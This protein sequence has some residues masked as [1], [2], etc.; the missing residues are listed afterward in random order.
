MSA[1]PNRFVLSALVLACAGLCASMAVAAPAASVAPKASATAK[2]AGKTSSA[3]GI[4]FVRELGGIKEYRLPNGLQVL[5]LPDESQETTLVNITYKVGSRHENYG[6]TGMAH[7]LEHMLFKGTPK[8]KDIPEEMGK[9]G[10]RWNAT[11]SQDRTNYF[12]SFTSSESNLN[13]ALSLEADRMRNSFVAKKDLDS[14]MTVVRNE[15]ERGENEP[16]RVL[17]QRVDGAAYQWHAYSRS[18]IGARS[19][20]ENVPIQNLQAFYQRWY[21]P[22][23]AVLAIGGRFDEAKALAK[24]AELFG[25]IANP[26]DPLPPEYTVEPAQDGERRVTVRRVGGQPISM[27]AYHVPGASHPDTAAVLVLGELLSQRP[28]GLLY[29]ELVDTRKAAVARLSG[30]LNSAPGLMRLI[31]VVN[32]GQSADEVEKR[33]QEIVQGV[34]V[35]AFTEAELTRVREQLTVQ[36][37]ELMKDPQG[38]TSLLSEAIA[39]G[40]WRLIFKLFEDLPKVTL[41]DVER[42][43]GQYLRTENRTVGRYEPTDKPVRVDVPANPDLKDRLAQVAEPPK[44]E[45]AEVFEPSPENLEKRV[46]RKLLPSGIQ[47]SVLP[48][49]TRGNTV[50]LRMDLR[51]AELAQTYNDP[52]SGWVADLLLEGSKSLSKQEIQDALTKLRAKVQLQGGPQGVEVTLQAEKQ[53]LLPALALLASVLREPLLPA[54]ALERQRAASLSSMEASRQEVGTLISEATRP[55]LND[56]MGVKKGDVGYRFSLD[57]RVAN[58]KGLTREA[59]VAFH[60]RYWSANDVQVGVVGPVPEGLE[61][62]LDGLIGSWKKPDAPAYKR[63]ETSH[64][65]VAAARVDV[66]A[67]DK[68]NASMSMSLRF[69]LNDRDADAPAMNLATAIFGSGME[70]RLMKRVRQKEGLTYGIGASVTIT[71]HGDRAG[72]AIGG[73]F[74]PENRDKVI[75]AVQ[76]E[77]RLSLKDGFTQA[78]LDRVRKDTLEGLKQQRADDGHIA[79]TMVDQLQEKQTFREL[80]QEEARIKSVTLEQLNAAWRK[81]V[82]A[83]GFL[84]VTAGDYKARPPVAP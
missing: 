76:D 30:S 57:E 36:Y 75:A 82:N 62:A 63:W 80:A 9:R 52:A 21:R 17:M 45:K 5:L 78:E 70:G 22:D 83:A 20:V 29:K 34:N 25:G 56:A 58:T 38:M 14:E 77:L 54:D 61:Q 74:A 31:T 81:H 40:D 3:A 23:N 18:T 44:V 8:F 6:E 84:T 42:V 50:V 7:L 55:L 1:S 11:T 43:R 4:Q 24:V 10:M 48:K 37:R 69:S 71:E 51:F 35:P 32:Q 46:V 59:I 49:Q 67:T 68:A 53:T 47:Y 19:D 79:S 72:L 60:G 26:H 66:Q 39:G 13:W 28:A 27:T 73:T 16:F 33:A 12:E 2:P 64:K 15:M 65:P 41:A